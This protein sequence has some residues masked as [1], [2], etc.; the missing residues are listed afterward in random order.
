MSPLVS[1]IVPV[2]ERRHCVLDAV[3]SVLAQ[4]HHDVECIVVDDGSSDGAF[5]A[6]VAA[7]ADDVRVRVFAQPHQG[8]SAARNLGIGEAR[9]EYLT[10][11][12]SDDLMPESRITRQ[13][14][15]LTERSC[16]AVLGKADSYAMPGVEAPVWVQSR[17]EWG[18][19]YAWIT[20]LVALRH[21]R[22]VG[23]FD[24]ALH[25]AEDIDMLVKLRA[26]GVRIVAVDD[27][28]VLRRFFGDNLTYALTGGGSGLRDSIRRHVA[29]QR[30][31]RG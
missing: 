15:L 10:F 20:I 28:F 31:S 5:D 9:G 25:M 18:N 17:P 16:D 26:A 30:T 2:F 29:R 22:S 12:D 11:L 24:E 6:V 3:E 8:V 27:T 19:G 23:G 21:V 14:E 4:T 1:V 13:L 7:Y